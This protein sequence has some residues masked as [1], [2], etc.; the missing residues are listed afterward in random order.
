MITRLR[1]LDKEIDVSFSPT[2]VDP[3]DDSFVDFSMP[4]QK[5]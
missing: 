1:T 2:S 3:D 4:S 5:I